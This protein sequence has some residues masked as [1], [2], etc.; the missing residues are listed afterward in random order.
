MTLRRGTFPKDIQRKDKIK[1]GITGELGLNAV[2]PVGKA[3]RFAGVTVRERNVVNLKKKCRKNTVNFLTAKHP[4]SDSSENR[5]S[6]L[7]LIK[8]A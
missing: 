8:Y 6:T 3:D 2:F 1:D 5:H 4:S 7:L